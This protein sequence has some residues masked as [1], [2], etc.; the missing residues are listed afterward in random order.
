MNISALS[1]TQ[2]FQSS[3]V[4]SSSQKNQLSDEQKDFVSSVLEGYDSD[5]LSQEDAVEIAS[6][7]QAAGIAPSRDLANTIADSGFSAHE[8]GELAGV[9]G[10]PAGAGGP[11]SAGGPPPP[12]PPQDNQEIQA[13]SSTLE[14]LLNIQATNEE[15]SSL[16]EDQEEFI[17]SLL[18]GYDASNISQEDATAIDSALKESGIMPSS[19]LAEVMA[20][21]G[22]NAREIGDLAEAE[23][24]PQQSSLESVSDYTSRIMSL[25][26]D[27]KQEVK[28]LFE[29]YSPENTQLSPQDASK[30]V[31]NSLSQILADSNNYKN[32]SFYG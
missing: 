19:Q 26:Q 4:S 25:T 8:I 27:V 2:T 30:V 5:S 32:T 28:D 16:S 18:S 12:P 15:E 29:S 1:S 11:R 13:I 3:S 17:S 23:R 7:F 24:P 20:Q 9:T 22:F 21:S 31:V 6:A 10:G 14:L